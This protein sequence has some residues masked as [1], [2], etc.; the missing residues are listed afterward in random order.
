M[1]TKVEKNLIHIE[2]SGPLINCASSN[3]L[4]L[5][6]GDDMVEKEALKTLRDTG[7]GSCG[8]RNFYGTLDVHLTFEQEM[9]KFLQ[10]ESAILYASGLATT[11]SVIPTFAGRG[12]FIVSDE[13]VRKPIQIGNYTSR[14]TVHY[15]RH[16]D[17]NHVEELMMK[18][19]EGI[20]SRGA[21]GV[22]RYVV[23]EGI[24]QNYGTLCRLPEVVALAKQYKFR[25]IVD[26]SV[27]LG[28]LGATG[29]GVLEH[30]N[31]KMED[32]SI[33]CADISNAIGSLGGVC[34]GRSEM[35]RVQRLNGSGYMYSASNPPYSASAATAALHKIEQAPR[36]VTDLQAKSKKIHQ[37]LCSIPHVEI[38]SHELCPFK[39]LRLSSQVRPD[40]PLEEAK[41]YQA[42]V[43]RVRD[44]GV[45]ITRTKYSN[46]ER[47]PPPPQLKVSLMTLH[48]DE[49]LDQ[50]ADAV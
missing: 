48:T 34:C 47:N 30:F 45:A 37:L 11:A 35:V 16:N 18:I 22:R 39:I 17:V 26:D 38:E 19:N 9:A 40:E 27:G 10:T 12:D 20:R 31:L 33:Y 21:K 8:P 5:A 13:C 50:I 36:L 23:V 49:Q 4:N 14:A 24:Y 41:L 29:R 1:V 2:N 42:I 44:L 25:V 46:S 3:F 28:C 43:D 32:I 6:Q 15:F 7:T